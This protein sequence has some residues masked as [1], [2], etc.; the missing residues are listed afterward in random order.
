MSG[1]FRRTLAAKADLLEIWSFIAD[2]NPDAA[3]RMLLK[4]DRAMSRLARNPGIGRPRPELLPGLRSYV[5]RPYVIFYTT[6]EDEIDIVRVLHGARDIESIF[7][8]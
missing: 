1:R 8:T 5:A 3:T 4:L 2:N 7:G 6:G